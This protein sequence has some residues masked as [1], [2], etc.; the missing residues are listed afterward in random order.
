MSKDD[1]MMKFIVRLADLSAVS[2][3][4]KAKK[5]FIPSSLGD[6]ALMTII[7]IMLRNHN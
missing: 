5:C 3:D 6:P 4:Y 7:V 1:R 2:Q